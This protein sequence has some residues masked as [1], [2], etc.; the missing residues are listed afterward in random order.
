M[1]PTILSALIGAGVDLTS[2]LVGGVGN[3]YG[4]RAKRRGLKALE[5]GSRELSTEVGSKAAAQIADLEALYGIDLQKYPELAQKFYDQVSGTDLSQ[6]EVGDPGDFQFDYKAETE[7]QMNPYLKDITEAAVGDVE[8]SAA[9]AGKLFSGAAGKEI[10]RATYDIRAKEYGNAADRAFRMGQQKYQQFTDK[11]NNILRGREFNKGLKM[12][13]IGLT[14]EGLSTAGAGRT[15]F[16]T[17]RRGITTAR[18]EAQL[19]LRSDEIAARTQ[20]QSLPGG[21]AAFAQGFA[22]GTEK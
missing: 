13:Q 15:A 4:N 5:E 12:D 11:F 21:F 7:A 18:D 9:N 16:D 3:I 19:G 8:Q 6:Y 20:R 10:A 1:D 22:G 17:G 2:G 14:K